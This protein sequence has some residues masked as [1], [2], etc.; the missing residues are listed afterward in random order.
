MVETRHT[1]WPG[2]DTGQEP[3]WPAQWDWFGAIPM[4]SPRGDALSGSSQ[5]PGVRPSRAASFS[6]IL[7]K[8]RLTANGPDGVGCRASC[9]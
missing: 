3:V 9:R 2:V 6:M 1:T 7:W 5:P 8:M 4:R